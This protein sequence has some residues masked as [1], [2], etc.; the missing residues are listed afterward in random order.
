MSQNVAM[1]VHPQYG[2]Q[3]QFWYQ[4]WYQN[5]VLAHPQPPVAMIFRA[6]TLEE[7]SLMGPY[8]ISGIM[9]GSLL[10]L[11]LGLWGVPILL[12]WLRQNRAIPL[13]GNSA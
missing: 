11:M 5:W 10:G 13:P 7:Y 12:R 3:F 6:S 9:C 2:L 1:I 4:N 8:E